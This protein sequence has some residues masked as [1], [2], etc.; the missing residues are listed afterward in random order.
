MSNCS[1]TDSYLANQCCDKKFLPV[2]GVR[3]LVGLVHKVVHSSRMLHLLLQRFG[4]FAPWQSKRSLSP[5]DQSYLCVRFVI[6]DNHLPAKAV[7]QQYGISKSR[8]PS[9][10]L[11]HRQLC[12]VEYQILSQYD[13]LN[14]TAA[15]SYLWPY[16]AFY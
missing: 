16:L 2:V 10:P 7:T 12:R 14:A 4:T 6:E 13:F 15:S 11:L 3:L 1:Y 8:Q 5:V 9:I